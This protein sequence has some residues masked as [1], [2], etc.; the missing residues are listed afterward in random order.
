MQIL[1]KLTM[2]E[3]QIHKVS[4]IFEKELLQGL[5]ADPEERKLSSLQMENTY[6]RALL[7]GKGWYYGRLESCFKVHPI[8]SFVMVIVI[9][10]S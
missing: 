1:N 9:N 3:E 4:Q 2:T 6:V 10:I 8:D 7:N 5:S